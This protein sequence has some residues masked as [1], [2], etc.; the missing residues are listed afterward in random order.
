MTHV[1]PLMLLASAALASAL[2]LPAQ[3][4]AEAQLTGETGD[5]LFKTYCAS[6]HGKSAKGD[7]PIAEHLRS[8]PPDLTLIAKRAGGKFDAERVHRVI[9]GRNPVGGHGGPDMPVWGDAF[10]RS[11]QGGTEEAVRARI[12]ALVEHLRSVQVQ[13][14]SAVPPAPPAAR[15]GPVARITPQVKPR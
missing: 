10:K 11:G 9:D 14:A 3:Q 6:C 4:T 1:M 15:S 8:R 13:P 5:Q 2:A 7:G 12:R